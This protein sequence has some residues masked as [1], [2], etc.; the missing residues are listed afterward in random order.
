ML[1]L[2]LCECGPHSPIATVRPILLVCLGLNWTFGWNIYNVSK[3]NESEK[4]RTWN[5]RYHNI[6]EKNNNIN[7]Q[8]YSHQMLHTC[9]NCPII[10]INLC[11][12]TFPLFMSKR[13]NIILVKT[14][15]INFLSPDMKPCVH[16]NEKL[17]L[18]EWHLTVIPLGCFSFK[19]KKWKNQELMFSWIWSHAKL[20]LL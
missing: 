13:T 17:E 16:N 1:S 10:I 6:I 20:L 14:E 4:Q 7:Y 12:T 11:L 19:F 3:N 9:S 5:I 8:N 18:L 15:T 2:C